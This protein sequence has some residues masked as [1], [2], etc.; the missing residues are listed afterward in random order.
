MMSAFVHAETQT[1][2]IDKIQD[3]YR[4]INDFYATFRQDATIKALD[5]IQTASGELW[6]KKD[7]KMRW[8]YNSPGH[9]QIVSDGANL[10]YYYKEENYVV[11]TDLKGMGGNPNLISLLSDLNNLN[12]LFKIK[13]SNTKEQNIPYYLI[14]LI[15]LDSED[16]SI[17]KISIAIEQDSLIIQK[18]LLYDPFDN[19]TVVKLNNIK[20]NKGIKDKIFDFKVP[21]GVEVVTTPPVLSN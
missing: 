5:K 18:L 4:S 12:N 21:K 14:D 2:V 11:K 1:D 13:V 6:I 10:W 7:A 20:I 9:D 3:K 15:P 16:E 17:N 19:L 8:N